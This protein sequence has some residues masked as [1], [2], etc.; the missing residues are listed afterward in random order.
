MVFHQYGHFFM[1]VGRNSAVY[2]VGKNQREMGKSLF[3]E[4]LLYFWLHLGTMST[5]MEKYL[6]L[7]EGST[8]S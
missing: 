4:E 5:S 8:F 1:F 2:G 7:L 3:W 6:P